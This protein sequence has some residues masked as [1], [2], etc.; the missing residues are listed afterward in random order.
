MARRG[1][2]LPNP[3]GARGAPEQAS[4]G[5]VNLGKA[6]FDAYLLATP[7]PCGR[8]PIGCTMRSTTWGHGSGQGLTGRSLTGRR[9]H[10]IAVAADRDAETVGRRRVMKRPGIYREGVQQDLQ[11]RKTKLTDREPAPCLWSPGRNAEETFT[12]APA[13]GDGKDLRSRGNV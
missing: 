7:T 5:L 13:A 11:T 2:A 12:G 4:A 9:I 3:P 6:G 10:R 1:L 8:R